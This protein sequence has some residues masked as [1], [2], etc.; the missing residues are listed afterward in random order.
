MRKTLSWIV[1]IGLILGIGQGAWGIGTAS[2]DAKLQIKD[3][4]RED[5]ML[6][7]NGTIWS[8]I[9]GERL[10]RTQ[11][12]V[13]EF[14]SSSVYSG[15]GVTSDGRLVEWDIGTAP[16]AVEGQTGV[17]QVAGPYWLKN[18]GTVWDSAGK[19]KNLE[20]IALISYGGKQMAALSQNGE[21][22]FRDPYKP[23]VFKKLATLP[24]ASSVAVMAVYE[25]RVALL[26]SSGKVV[27]YQTYEFDDNGNFIPYTVT[28]DA[29]HLEFAAKTV[30]HPTEAL[31]VTRKDGT[32]WTTGNYKDR[33]K[34]TDQ[35][36]G[37][38]KV[39]KTRVLNDMEHFYAQLSDGS[40]LLYDKGKTTPLEVPRAS[41]LTVAVSELKPFVGDTVD[42]NIQETYTNGANIKVTATDGNV[43]VEKPHLL[44]IEPDGSLKVLGVGESNVTIASSGI[45]ETVTISASLRSNLKYSKMIGGVVYVPAKSV[46]QALGGKA[47]SS[48]GGLD[49]KLG[50]TSLFFK[51]EDKSAVLN[52]ENFMLKAAPVM[53]KGEVL[54][55]A[56]LLTDKLG[57]TVK[58]DSKWKQANISFGAA[59]MTIVSSETASLVKKAMQGS[60]AKYI[61]KS[62]WVN[63]YLGWERFSK[64]T[65]TDISPNDSG[66]FVVFFK[67]AS[68]KTLKS[69][70]LSSSSVSQLFSDGYFFLNY[71]PY[72][73]Y[74]WSASV[75]NKIK[76]GQIDYGMTK[77]QVLF[78]WGK[79]AGK[80]T[81]AKN[82]KTI[83]TWVYRNFDTIAFINGK[84]SV[85]IY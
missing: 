5:T 47:S 41:K 79:L 55:P 9:D 4:I 17:K 22:L 42:V 38:S 27:L 83:E 10:I 57:A 50:D 40:W 69:D 35:V 36:S 30:E 65:V 52:G 63:D 64:V 56:S 45:S 8:S 54:I 61:G 7:D 77:E 3:I 59:Q 34:L 71:D 70:A 74:S 28:E 66:A 44:R 25:S 1:S 84:V 21:L 48:G 33:V 81:V 62:F 73:K 43:S 67:S 49:V 75:W 19:V 58:W 26:Y 15:L 72:K 13:D 46:F 6:M 31:L 76:A 82:G 23:E 14:T 53:E 12:S 85:I 2:A 11:G 18:D 39:V 51:A 16:H 78:S 80:S 24:D 29:L 60:L 20:G 37:L 32:V 68:G